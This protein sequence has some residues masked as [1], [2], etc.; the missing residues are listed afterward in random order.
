MLNQQ[1]Q[2]LNIRSYCRKLLSNPKPVAIYL[3]RQKAS[4]QENIM[5]VQAP[6]N[7]TCLYRMMDEASKITNPRE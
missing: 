4:P 2:V 1:G 7:K 6:K 3:T 5:T